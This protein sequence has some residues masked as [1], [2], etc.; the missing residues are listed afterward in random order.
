MKKALL[1]FLIIANLSIYLNA[2]QA[3]ET[4]RVHDKV[5]MTWYGAY[6][7]MGYFP[8]GSK[9]YEQILL[10]YTMGCASGGCS[11][12]DYT[13]KIELRLPTGL[14]DSTVANL[15]TI[16]TNP[17]QV[18]TTWNVFE[19]IEPMELARVI[20]PYGGYMAQGSN[21]YNNDWE[22]TH[23]FD[24][25][26]FAYLLKDS[27]EVRAFYDGWSSGFSVTLDFEFTEGTPPREV[28][29]IQNIYKGGA[30]YQ[31]SIQ[32]ETEYTSEKNVNIPA[33]I[34]SA[35]MRII[36]SGHGFDNNTSCAEFCQRR[37][38]LNV[39][40][41]EVANVIMWDDQCGENPIY[42]QGGTWLYD[43]ANWCP[44]M[45]AKIHE[46]E[47]TNE[48][49]AGQENS[50]DMDFQNISWS[51]NQAPYYILSAQL[52]TYTEPIP[53]TDL[54][55]SKV[56]APNNDE[57]YSRY[58]P[59]CGNPIIE[60]A[61]YGDKPITRFIVEYGIERANFEPAPCFYEWT[62]LLAQGAKEEITLP[63]FEWFDVDLENPKFYAEVLEINNGFDDMRLNNRVETSFE[64][65]PKLSS[66]T[67]LILRT[68]NSPQETDMFLYDEDGE[69]VDSQTDFENSTNYEYQWV[70]PSGCY[71]LEVLDNTPSGGDGLSWWANNE[72]TG[73]VR[74]Y[75]SQNNLIEDFNPDF[76]AFIKYNFT[77]G[78]NLGERPEPNI[79]CTDIT[80][81]D[82][83]DPLSSIEN[84]LELANINIFPNP[85]NG[86][87]AIDA[88][89]YS[90]G[91]ISIFNIQGKLIY[92]ENAIGVN[93]L[94]LDLNNGLYFVKIQKGNVV[95]TTPI[96]IIKE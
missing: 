50:I 62:G 78:Y 65:T 59:I 13:T 16:S 54:A 68:N 34:Q 79:E 66:Q 5:D 70:L 49:I 32:F 17:M 25:T 40:N 30:N 15:D 4:I 52:I 2:Q 21:G 85:S 3:T 56:I 1:L 19:V 43:R 18:D 82:L 81:P 84:D 73:W 77:V 72:G 39:N 74:I 92:T 53:D 87:F 35:K 26:D 75:D 64:I 14:M 80:N 55:I 7:Q 46:H 33:N 47:I 36:P 63:R 88:T 41:E 11:D 20:T 29:S 86:N 27:L 76:G 23:T 31:N 12:W 51:G 48:I 38:Y 61:N 57:N 37:Y 93:N 94:N 6:D 8:D 22:H 44:G 42:P 91:E 60:V 9:T 24:I 71:T 89:D 95:T 58:N 90:G 83:V 45:P 10:H 67:K 28:H 69:I 96:T